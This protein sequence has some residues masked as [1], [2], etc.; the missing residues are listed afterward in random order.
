VEEAASMRGSSW[1]WT[2]GGGRRRGGGSID[3]ER[4]RVNLIIWAGLVLILSLRR[5]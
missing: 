2:N 1:G 3:G 4:D 5:Y